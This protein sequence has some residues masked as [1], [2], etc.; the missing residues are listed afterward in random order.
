MAPANIRVKVRRGAA[1]AAFGFIV[2]RADLTN[3]GKFDFVWDDG[4]SRRRVISEIGY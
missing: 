3:K 2:G 1:A 4:I